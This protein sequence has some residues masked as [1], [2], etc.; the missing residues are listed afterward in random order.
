MKSSS[1][2]AGMIIFS[3]LNMMELNIFDVKLSILILDFVWHLDWFIFEKS[4]LRGSVKKIKWY[5]N[6]NQLDQYTSTVWSS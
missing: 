3:M 1:Y 5:D 6:I 2:Y 4:K